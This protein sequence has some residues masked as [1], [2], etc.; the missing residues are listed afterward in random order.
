MMVAGLN[1]KQ[2]PDAFSVGVLVILMILLV[3]KE[4][5]STKRSFSRLRMHDFLNIFIFLFGVLF[6]ILFGIKIWNIAAS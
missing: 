4:M 6:L 1:F 3:A 5:L 2:I